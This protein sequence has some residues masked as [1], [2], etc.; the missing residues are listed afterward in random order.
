MPQ[1]LRNI[2][3]MY[4]F[5]NAKVTSGGDII[6]NFKT[7]PCVGEVVA[8]YGLVPHVFDRLINDI[9]DMSLLAKKQILWC[10]NRAISLRRKCTSLPMNP[11]IFVHFNRPHINAGLQSMLS[12]NRC[13]STL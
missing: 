9:Q 4:K 1:T 7:G 3:C 5:L 6:Y 13:Q 12:T 8:L 11:F 2:L 10:P